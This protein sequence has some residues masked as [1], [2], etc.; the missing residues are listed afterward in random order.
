M[1]R[2][3]RQAR[4]VVSVTDSVVRRWIDPAGIAYGKPLMLGKCRQSSV[5]ESTDWVDTAE[6]AD[7]LVRHLQE[8]KVNLVI[9]QG[10]ARPWHLCRSPHGKRACEC[11]ANSRQ[12]FAVSASLPVKLPPVL[13]ENV[14]RE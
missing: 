3:T 10:W 4:Q 2:R 6:R 11:R 12:K 8:S 5:G 9:A 14:G 1:G 7:S 13:E